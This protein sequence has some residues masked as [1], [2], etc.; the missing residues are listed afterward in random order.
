[1]LLLSKY[2]VLMVY[3]IEQSKYAVV[4]LYKHV[5]GEMDMN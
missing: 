5:Y 3:D 1:V 2:A 4:M